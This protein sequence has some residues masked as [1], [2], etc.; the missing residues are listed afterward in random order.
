M[1][2]SVLY[3]VP[4]SVPHS[5]PH[6]VPHSIPHSMFAFFTGL[7]V[8][9]CKF[10]TY[11]TDLHTGLQIQPK[12]FLNRFPRFPRKLTLC[13]ALA[14]KRFCWNFE[15]LPPHCVTIYRNFSPIPQV[16]TS[17]TTILA[18]NNL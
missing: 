2:Y 10:H 12:R 11:S 18:K 17:N 9:F 14:Q 7:S 3:S 13:A 6:S 1:L 16:Y 4:R 5:I 15:V 8:A